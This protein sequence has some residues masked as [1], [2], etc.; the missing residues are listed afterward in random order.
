M[1]KR[2]NDADLNSI[3]T[4]V[5]L[6]FDIRTEAAK[7]LM[8]RSGVKQ[9]PRGREPK[10]HQPVMDEI[11]ELFEFPIYELLEKVDHKLSVVTKEA[12][13]AKIPSDF[14]ENYVRNKIVDMIDQI[15]QNRET[16]GK[17]GK[18]RRKEA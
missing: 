5:H 16:T 13:V 1:M 3:F 9:M 11:F 12:G 8:K 6:D 2:L 10:D 15:A 7:E 4:N 14:R 18:N 17:G